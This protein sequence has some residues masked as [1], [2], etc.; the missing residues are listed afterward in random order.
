MGEKMKEK[1]KVISLYNYISE[2]SKNSKTINKNISD[3]KWYYFLENLPKDNNIQFN[4]IYNENI[5][6]IKKPDYLKPLKLKNEFLPWINGN[7]ENYK[8]NITIKLERIIEK[9]ISLEDGSL[10]KISEIENIS[11]ELELS[12][13]NEIDK[14]EI[15]VKEQKNIERIIKIFNE[16]YI[17]Y[18]NLNKE[19]ETF[20]LVLANGL[21]KIENKNIYYPI[22]LKKV[23]F[24]FNAK[25]NIIC[26]KN[27]GD[28]KSVV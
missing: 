2:V 8:E 19:S 9:I 15:W 6:R 22:L 16:L 10:K 12:I 4:T 1:E 3:E 13:S 20:E 11:K 5:L 17:Q 18:L 28:R 25:E 27:I 24:E 7:W 26:I 21:V 14:R 23:L